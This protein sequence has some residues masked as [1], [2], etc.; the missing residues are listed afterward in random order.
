[1]S[2]ATDVKDEIS[3]LTLSNSE[4]IAELSAFIRNNEHRINGNI[5]LYTE[6]IYTAKKIYAFL[7]KLSG[8]NTKMKTRQNEIFNK[9]NV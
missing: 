3:N 9:N 2:F 6:N 8:I 4:Y 1:M 5:V 7:K